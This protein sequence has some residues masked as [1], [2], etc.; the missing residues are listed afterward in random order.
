MMT[1]LPKALLVLSVALATAPAFAQNAGFGVSRF[2]PAERGSDWFATDSLDLSGHGRLTV[3]AVGEYQYRPLV[4]YNAD[5]S[6][7]ASVVEHLL[8]IHPGASFVLWERLRLGANLPVALYADGDGGSLQGVRYSPP[9]SA[10][11]LGD[12]RLGADVRVLGEKGDLA[13]VAVGTQLWL[14]TGNRDAYAGDGRVRIAPRAML[15]GEAGVFVYAAQVGAQFRRNAT[16]ASAPVGNELTFALSAGVRSDDKKLVIGPELFG[17]TVF[18]DAFAR[19]TT[20]LEALLGAHYLFGEVKV[21]GGVGTGLSRGY[22]TPVVHVLAGLEWVPALAKVE[23]P[24]DRDKD[25]VLDADDACID[26]PGV[27]ST[28][29]AKNGCPLPLDRDKDG[30]LDADD[31]C[32]DVPGVASADRTKHGCPVPADRDKDGVLDAD[33]AC[34]DVPGNKTNDAKTNGCPDPDRDKDGIANAED[35]CPDEAGKAD[36]DPKRN[37]CPKAF[38]QAGQI[39]ILDQVKFKTSSAEISPGKDS[40]EVLDA[41]LG[42]LQKFPEIKKV[43]VEGHTDSRGNAGFNKQLSANRAASVVKWLI[44][45]GVAAD[46]L[47]SAGFGPERPLDTNETDAGRQNNRRV[48]FHIAEENKP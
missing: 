32:I 6:V 25:G 12:L 8:R 28:D 17:S 22:G 30:I 11:S 40:Q 37:G 18:D 34:P 21:G 29:R 13:T 14:P 45:K 24:S 38:V 46:R 41:V 2:E 27:A 31:A 33:D 44:G 5:D 4:I 16:Y 3:G 35:A 23:A 42:V 43:R 36:P 39:R 20:P 47:T 9:G 15:A 19:K 26:V 7:R 48:E 1:H 10:Q